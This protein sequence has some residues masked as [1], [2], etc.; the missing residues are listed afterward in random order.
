MT[1]KAEQPAGLEWLAV[2]ATV[3]FIYGG[4][5]D[6]RVREGVVDRIG[7]RDVVVTIE[8]REEKFNITHASR[9][10]DTLW[11]HR[12][13]RSSWDRGVYLAPADHPEVLAIQA[14]RVRDDAA[15]EVSLAAEVFQRRRDA[16]TAQILRDA[17]DAFLK[18]VEES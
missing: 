5:H 18:L 12:R 1:E 10:G 4:H 16:A 11:L 3:A 14:A 9:C 2:G 8:G 17:V 7:K 13:G 6:E 15:Y